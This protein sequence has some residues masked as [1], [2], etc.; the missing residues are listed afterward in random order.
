MASS[1]LTSIFFSPRPVDETLVLVPDYKLGPVIASGKTSSGLAIEDSFSSE[2]G[3]FFWSRVIT[4]TNAVQAPDSV[5]TSR[6]SSFHRRG[7]FFQISVSEAVGRSSVPG[8]FTQ[9]VTT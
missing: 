4:M 6:Y 7:R 2:V 3:R 9:L 1:Y 5:F 8:R